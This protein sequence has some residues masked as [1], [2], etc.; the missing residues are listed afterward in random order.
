VLSVETY[1][2]RLLHLA[3]I[4]G[5]T[6]VVELL[7]D[8][9]VDVNK[10]SPIEPLVLL[11][12]MCAARYKRRSAVQAVL[13]KRG[14]LDDIFT[15][16]FLG[17][18]T[19]LDADLGADSGLAQAVDPAVDALEITPIHHAVAGEQVQALRLLLS[20]A[21][22]PIL[23]ATRALRLAVARG[24]VA[25]VGL[26]LERGADASS[27]GAGRWVLHPV[28]A[29]LLS[30]AGAGVDRSGAWIGAA[31]TG[32]QSRRDDP[33][34]VAALLRH[35]ARVDDRREIGQDNDGGRAT[36]LHYAARAGF[37]NTIS[38]L[39]THGADPSARDDNGLTPLDWLDR[40]AR[41]VDRDKVR[42]LLRREA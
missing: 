9:G 35:G 34:Y 27:I 5:R 19:G 10:P 42:Q 39:L 24:N 40:S 41:S 7:L 29:P 8:S 2:A 31:C 1:A 3:A 32:N 17:D 14:A 38:V 20:R 25:L 21:T 16:A 26:L 28:L 33:D 36:A 11:T 4:N 30:Q 12:P 6:A 23:N 15:R 13:E 22:L 18:V 37:V